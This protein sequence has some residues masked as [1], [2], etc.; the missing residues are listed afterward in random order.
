MFKPITRHSCRGIAAALTLGTATAL[1]LAVFAP[2]A[3]AQQITQGSINGTATPA[4]NQTVVATN[5]GTGL[6]RTAPVGAD[7]KFA[8]AVLP[9]GTYSLQLMSN[10]QV[11]ATQDGITV[12]A[13]VGTTVDFTQQ[14]AANLGSV[15]VTANSITP[16]DVA[17]SSTSLIVNAQQL[18]KL[19][20]PQSTFSVALLAP[21]VVQNAAFSVPS[22]GG[23][24][25][26][27]NAYY[28]DGLNVTDQYTFLNLAQPPFEA[29]D[30]FQVKTGGITAGYGNALGG[31]VN[32]STK[33]GSND[34]HA[35]ANILWDPRWQEET[36]PNV[37]ATSN[38]CGAQAPGLMLNPNYDNTKPESNS[39][40][41][42]MAAPCNDPRIPNQLLEHNNDNSNSDFKFNLW[43][44]GALIQDRL[45][46]YILGQANSA[47]NDTYGLTTS[48]H[49]KTTSPYELL[50][51]D[52]NIT[53]NNVFTLTAWN[54]KETDDGIEYNLG[55]PK[56]TIG[57]EGINNG[58]Q[59]SLNT[60]PGP[61]YSDYRQTTIGPYTNTIGNHAMIGK[62]TWFAGP[63]FNISALLGY[64]R[65]DRSLEAN[66]DCPITDDNRSG[67]QVRI[68]CWVVSNV[69]AGAY[70][71]RHE[72][73]VDGE[74][75]PGSGEAGFAGGHDITFGY[76][77]QDFVSNQS[78]SY[79][80]PT[81][82]Q[83]LPDGSV[84]NVPG[85]DWEYFLTPSTGVVNGVCYNTGVAPVAGNCG[86]AANGTDF[87][88]NGRQY[89]NFGFFKNSNYAMYIQD[90]WHMTQ[91]FYLNFGVR[92][93]SF[94]AANAA[95]QD[96][97]SAD[98][99]IGPRLGFSWDV[100]GDSHTK[101]YGSYAE[102]FIPLSTDAN[103]RGAGAALD[104]SNQDCLA[105]SID[106]TTGAPLY[107]GT[108]VTL[109]DG[110]TC[111]T[112]GSPKVQGSGIP[113]AYTQVATTNF[114]P[115]AE[116]EL[117]LGFDKDLSQNWT[118]GVRAVHRWL[119]DGQDDECWFAQGY[120]PNFDNW[121]ATGGD[122]QIGKDAA[123]QDAFW[124]SLAPTTC[125][126]ANP[127]EDIETVANLTDSTVDAAHP[128]G[129][130]LSPLTI[131]NSVMGTP[132]A[133]RTYNAMEFTLSR[134][135]SDNWLFGASYTWAHEFGNEEGYVL[136]TI[137]QDD[138]GLTESFDFPK[139]EEGAYGNLPNDHR[140]T[141]KAWGAYQ[142]MP[143]WR[144]G[145]NFL[146]ESGMPVGCYGTYPD[147]N[148]IAFYYGAFSNWCGG[149]PNV[150]VL[151][152]TLGQAGSY[153]RTPWIYNLD[154]SLAW[155][156]TNID[157][158]TVQLNW[159]NVLG[160][161]HPTSYVQQF[162]DGTGVPQNSFM[163]ANT[164]QQPSYL[165]LTVRYQFM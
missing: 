103:I 158:L 105:N 107:N 70:D 101:V 29:L 110:G 51:L 126:I 132:A 55:I 60:S 155:T 121:V 73:R 88:V 96:F 93:E 52:W 159:Y 90:N 130:T 85:V 153:S 69:T 50:R 87:Y 120:N 135:F 106:P 34:F 30:T 61:L 10:G 16:I 18:T 32:M 131:P 82:T 53:D 63:S 58:D 62:Y 99:E 43:A 134:A 38:A 79:V 140:H 3:Q 9:A 94:K 23:A 150:G 154:L 76:D 45:F 36:S 1:S 11:V 133:K 47:V 97:V 117:I 100:N 108:P 17:S 77:H 8:L 41:R 5:T 163:T 139:L 24:S 136:S 81:V 147:E 22:F 118:Y 111:K 57:G 49:V 145:A 40:L 113:P 144:L 124:Q 12:N 148:Y 80:G 35:G 119:V 33:S 26:A 54:S 2:V 20:V 128:Y 162:D 137:A 28:V 64:V 109:G 74:W 152:G 44:S 151:T 91:N 66:A 59:W 114:T 6:S 115:M 72:Y 78:Q 37:Y 48:A 13:G 149:T 95:G 161:Q 46:Y 83:T 160:T 123:H 89:W 86:Y 142:F 39:N 7:G 4:P 125:L 164:F 129:T 67:T 141:I 98:N 157:G 42:Y 92:D 104:I 138:P 31:V 156:P 146:L 116:K 143:D 68:G 19:P 102:Y 71:A 14:Q 84:A 21:S 75:T 127:G 165:E 122:G 112:L 27:E 65:F 25:S 56:D 15:T